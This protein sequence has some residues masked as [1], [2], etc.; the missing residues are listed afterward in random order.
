MPE[1]PT[2]VG[3]IHAR[4]GS[5][6]VP[7]KNIKELAGKPLIA[8]IIDAALESETLDRVIIS[9]DHDE[10]A[11]IARERGAEVP[12]K[13]PAEISED[14]PSEMVTQH[15]VRFLE[16]EEGLRVD[17][18]V[19]MQPTAPFCQSG[20]I[21]ECVRT[22]IDSGAETVVTAREVREPPQW[23]F[24]LEGDKAVS[25]MDQTM[26]GD[27]GVSQ[28]LP[29]FYMPNGGI[30]ATRRD[31]LMEQGLWM[32]KDLR[33]VI[34]PWERSLDIDEPIDFLIAEAFAH[35]MV[36]AGENEE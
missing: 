36:L 14:V 25:F 4:G 9:T 3:I 28:T 5:K 16:E 33:L 1:K 11:R 30:Y 22:L 10:I 29:K 7:L 34:M 24:K 32:G 19:S 20:D 12:F 17:I 23:M 26:K 8:W 2:I 21:D 6:R 13:R 31:V 27:I 35:Q 18:A 15:A